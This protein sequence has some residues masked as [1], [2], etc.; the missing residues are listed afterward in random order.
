MESKCFEQT[1]IKENSVESRQR[2]TSFAVLGVLLGLLMG[3]YLQVAAAPARSEDRMASSGGVYRRPLAQ[4]P[5]SLD[6]ARASS[7]YAATV[8]NQ[9][10]DGLVQFD[11]HLNPIPALAGFWEASPDGLTWTFHLRQGVMFHHGREVTADD[12]VY[13]FTRILD[14]ALQSTVAGT[15]KHIRGAEAFRAGQA[16][17]VE[18]L[19]ALDRH[20]LQIVLQ[21]PYAPFLSILAMTHAKVVPQDE[22]ERLGERF[23][24]Q[25]VGSGAFTFLQWERQQRIVLQANEAY[26]EG[27]PFLDRLVFEIGKR[28]VE[29]LSAFLAGEL[30]EAT[31]PSAQAEALQKD[32]RYRAYPRFRKPVLHLLYIGFNLR[33]EPFTHS[34]VR[35]AFNYAINQEAI[36]QEIRKGN[37]IV[38]NGILPPGM[39]GYNPELTG[40]P[41]DPQRAKQ[42]LAEAGYPEGK[43]LPVIDLWYSSKEETTPKEL[44][45]YRGYLAELGVKVEIREAA[46]W[47]ALAAMLDEGKA[48]MFRLAWYSDIPDP[49]NFFSPLLAA[50]SKNNRMFYRNAQVER[51]LEE[52][53][54]EA[55]YPRRIEIYR[56][57]EQLVLHDAP[58][59]SQHHQTFE[60]LYQPYVQGVETNA[61]GAPYVLMK[62][63]WLQK[64]AERKAEKK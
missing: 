6:P 41:Y 21:E 31:V 7:I 14:P 23:G 60:N 54:R 4:D 50:Q 26:Y 11:N 56:E 22:V 42:L 44:E 29:N 20:T 36:V 59:I 10:F 16:S 57:V 33:K 53:R 49:D 38:A 47:S 9:V 37:S 35:Q 46:N 64:A 30:E 63:F 28:D 13:S 55:N 51:L 15:F 40:Y 3:S 1:L 18:G 52:A 8:I 12:V 32:P 61:L 34:K 48:M 27:R 58:W 19:R 24:L 2:Y 45:A 17:Q 25:P 43:G 5:A 39:P 62:K